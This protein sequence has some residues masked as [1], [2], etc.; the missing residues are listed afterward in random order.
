MA[1]ST[2]RRPVRPGASAALVVAE[3]VSVTR[4]SRAVLDGVSLR[5]TGGR[6]HALVG[7]N[8]SGKS[9]LLHTLAGLVRCR[10]SIA[11]ALPAALLSTHPGHHRDRTLRDHL[12]IAGRQPLVDAA[13]LAELVELFDLNGLLD[14]RPRAMSLGQ[15][16]AI[17][18]LAPLAS[19]APMVLLD[20]PFLALDARRTSTLEQCVRRAA[21]AGRIV[22][23]SSHELAPLARCSTELLA[24]S[25]GRVT[26]T[27]TVDD[28]IARSC[29][30]R[31]LVATPERGRFA[32]LVELEWG[33][34]A[35]PRP[36]GRLALTGR[37]MADV[38]DLCQRHAVPLGGVWDEVT[39]LDDAVSA[40]QLGT[41]VAA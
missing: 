20:E 27:G 24:L 30:V 34:M 18:L 28:L 1:D 17:G 38:L 2:P 10:G 37:R 22:V 25:G 26:F 13:T 14:R 6:V 9:T 23:V 31:V 15:Q 41:E 40:A 7:P 29:P 35:H 21:A 39:T 33:L 16:R 12:R 3:D 36:D 19:T 8:G 4:G 5:L 32:E 11:P